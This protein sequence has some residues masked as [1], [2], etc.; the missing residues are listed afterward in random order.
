[1]AWVS[2][3]DPLGFFPRDGDCVVPRCPVAAEHFLHFTRN[4]L[5]LI[6]DFSKELDSTRGLGSEYDW[7]ALGTY[8]I[9]C[10]LIGPTVRGCKF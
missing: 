10:D 3:R 8:H 1:M 5:E 7:E 9:I 2:V 6:R 4:N